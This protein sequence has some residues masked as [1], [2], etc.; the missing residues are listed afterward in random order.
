MSSESSSSCSL[1]IIQDKNSYSPLPSSVIN[2]NC[3]KR[4]PPFQNINKTKPIQ[5]KNFPNNSNYTDS[6]IFLQLFFCSIFSFLFFFLPPP[7]LSPLLSFP[8]FLLYCCLLAVLADAFSKDDIM[9]N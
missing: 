6:D 7:L 3:S 1:G 9:L 5:I 4:L 2:C 8:L